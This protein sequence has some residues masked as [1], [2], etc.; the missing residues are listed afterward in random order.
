MSN[1]CLRWLTTLI[2]CVTTNVQGDGHVFENGCR[3]CVVDELK[4]KH[5]DAVHLAQIENDDPA[6]TFDIFVT[7]DICKEE[8]WLA[9]VVGS[10]K[11]NPDN[12]PHTYGGHVEVT[13]KRTEKRGSGRIHL[14]KIEKEDE[15]FDIYLKYEIYREFCETDHSKPKAA[16]SKTANSQDEDHQPKPEHQHGDERGVGHGREDGHVH[17]QPESE[18]EHDVHPHQEK[19]APE[20]GAHPKSPAAQ[21]HTTH[22]ATHMDA[23]SGEIVLFDPDAGPNHGW[24]DRLGTILQIPFLY[25]SDRRIITDQIP[26]SILHPERGS[27]S[28]GDPLRTEQLF[29]FIKCSYVYD[30]YYIMPLGI[31]R[32]E[33][34]SGSDGDNENG[35]KEVK[36]KFKEIC[37][38]IQ[39]PPSEY[40]V[41]EQYASN[42][43]LHQYQATAK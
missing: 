11:E 24:G 27:K 37:W 35:D 36:R 43:K 16:H 9:M 38:T 12:H 5:P 40:L 21:R 30:N 33:E 4:N 39:D 41:S 32:F 14:A 17:Q 8:H 20:N 28:R 31:T 22:Q 2:A 13:E 1:A 42:H 15:T 25:T 23:C 10:F 7:K 34:I 29:C 6:V 19:S 3:K 26:K 18:P